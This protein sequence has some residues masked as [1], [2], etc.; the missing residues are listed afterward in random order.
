MVAISV[1]SGCSVAAIDKFLEDPTADPVDEP[2]VPVAA[3]DEEQEFIVLSQPRTVTNEEAIEWIRSHG[4]YSVGLR[5]GDLFSS[6]EA[7]GVDLGYALKVDRSITDR[8]F[9]IPKVIAESSYPI[10]SCISWTLP[11]AYSVS[12]TDYVRTI[13]DVVSQ[14][15]LKA[16]HFA[17]NVLFL[18]ST[19]KYNSGLCS[20]RSAK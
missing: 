19:K 7:L 3:K 14:Y 11:V 17:N 10:P 4:D 13:N 20:R 16:V 8:S 18:T 15:D 12:S 5:E 1:T 2:I 6:I 9:N